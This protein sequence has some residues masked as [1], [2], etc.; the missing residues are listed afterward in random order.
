MCICINVPPFEWSLPLS[1]NY[2]PMNIF[3]PVYIMPSEFHHSFLNSATQDLNSTNYNA[4]INDVYIFTYMWRFSASGYITTV[5]DV[6]SV[7]M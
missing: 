6:P 5:A 1:R 2:T 4:V 3:V 7:R